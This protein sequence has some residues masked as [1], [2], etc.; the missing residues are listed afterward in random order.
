MTEREPQRELHRRCP[1]PL[2][3][4]PAHHDRIQERHPCR[5]RFWRNLPVARATGH[6]HGSGVLPSASASSASGRRALEQRSPCA[7]RPSV[8]PPS[9]GVK[10]RCGLRWRSASRSGFAPPL[11]PCDAGGVGLTMGLM[12][13]GAGHQAFRP[14][15]SPSRGGVEG[16]RQRCCH[17]HW[18][19]PRHTS[20]GAMPPC[21]RRSPTESDAEPD[22]AEIGR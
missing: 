9:P 18:G 16:I 12:P 17:C 4:Q 14:K 19:E 11:T 22:H 8:P 7:G 20:S 6:S 1:H 5:F 3:A 15:P 21:R 2:S 13:A 10:G